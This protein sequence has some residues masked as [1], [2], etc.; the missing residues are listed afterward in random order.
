[1]NFYIKNVER[2]YIILSKTKEYVV[3]KLMEAGCGTS[4]VHK[5][6][7]HIH[8]NYVWLYFTASFYVFFYLK[9]QIHVI[10]VSKEFAQTTKLILPDILYVTS[11]K[12]FSW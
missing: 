7:Y 5:F 2:I 12:S 8:L 9:I 1:M 3:L 10:V 11:I 4:Q 6:Q